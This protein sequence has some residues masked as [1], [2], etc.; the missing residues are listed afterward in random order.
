MSWKD[1]EGLK[2][3]VDEINNENV[4]FSTDYNI[5]SQWVL[6][7]Y[8]IFF[9]GPLNQSGLGFVLPL[10][11]FIVIIIMSKNYRGNIYNIDTK[12]FEVIGLRRKV[13]RKFKISDLELMKS[14][15][16]VTRYKIKDSFYKFYIRD[17]I[18]YPVLYKRAIDELKIEVK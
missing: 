3:L 5:Y 7:L 18:L 14:K 17:I 4:I 10:L 13:I 8:L 16:T 11:I 9:F 12:E 2:T 1:R 15:K 6:P